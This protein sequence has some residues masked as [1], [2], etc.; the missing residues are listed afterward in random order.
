MT[1]IQTYS[2]HKFYPL[3]PDNENSIIDIQ[4]IAHSLSMQ[5]RFNGHV[6]RFYSVAQHSCEVADL[7]WQETQSPELTLWGLLHDAAETYLTD[8]PKPVKET[9]P[10][11]KATEEKLLEAIMKHFGLSWPMPEIVNKYDMV[12]LLTER[13]WLMGFVPDSWKIEGY[14]P[15]PRFPNLVLSQ[16]LSKTRFLNRFEQLTKLMEQTNEKD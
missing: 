10:E 11:Y 12:M 14:E 2:S 15:L 3:E 16:E 7:I 1:W 13:D 5:C 6:R 9:L 4:D 8:L